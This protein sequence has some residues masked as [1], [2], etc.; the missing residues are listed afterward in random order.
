MSSQKNTLLSRRRL[1]NRV[2]REMRANQQPTPISRATRT[3]K[4]LTTQRIS[5]HHI[6]NGPRQ[7]AAFENED[8]EED[9]FIGA[10]EIR[11]DICYKY[12]YSD[13]YNTYYKACE[14]LFTLPTNT[15]FL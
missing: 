12:W 2:R 1:L 10:A 13:T 7:Q 3:H 5:D 9:I 8:D 15:R 11:G 4:P 6:K 14:L